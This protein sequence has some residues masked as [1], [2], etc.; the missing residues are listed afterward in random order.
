MV[1]DPRYMTCGYVSAQRHG[2]PMAS[3]SELTYEL[4]RC[5]ATLRHEPGALPSANC[6]PALSLDQGLRGA[7]QAGHR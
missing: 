3:E 2:L 4:L 5:G 7:A 1:N 6:R